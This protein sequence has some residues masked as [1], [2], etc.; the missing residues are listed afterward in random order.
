MLHPVLWRL[1]PHPTSARPSRSRLGAAAAPNALRLAALLLCVVCAGCQSR[2]TPTSPP[3][4]PGRVH[5]ERFENFGRESAQRIAAVWPL[6]MEATADFDVEPNLVLGVIWVES[7]FRPDA[8]SHMGARG[9]MQLM[10]RTARGLA[11]QLGLG[12]PRSYD[13]HFNVYA[14]TYFLHRLLERYD[15]V[16]E[17]AVAA[18]FAGPGNVTKWIRRGSGLSASAT[19]YADSVLRARARFAA[20]TTQIGRDTSAST[21]LALRHERT[22]ADADQTREKDD[23]S[24]RRDRQRRR[25][26]RYARRHSAPPVEAWADEDWLEGSREPSAAE[27]ARIPGRDRAASHANPKVLRPSAKR[28]R[29]PER[30]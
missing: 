27:S 17:L 20:V 21:R 4:L 1:R 28:R 23:S 2:D 18:Y 26:R 7:R 10:P 22:R 6:V 11:E 8:K 29:S 14:G 30:T 16:T 3:G 24:R 13:P 12:R 5:P 9:L 19:K 15:G 25:A